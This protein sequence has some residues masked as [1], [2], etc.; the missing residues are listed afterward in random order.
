[1]FR[2]IKI[3][4]H[5]FDDEIKTDKPHYIP[6]KDWSVN[7]EGKI[8]CLT[9]NYHYFN[10]NDVIYFSTFDGVVFQYQVSIE[11]AKRFICEPLD[12]LK[13]K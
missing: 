12:V 6:I 1:M 8:S 5:T 10:E 3:Q 4:I 7:D 9:R 13:I 11:N 2:I